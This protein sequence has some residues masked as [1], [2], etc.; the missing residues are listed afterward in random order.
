MHGSKEASCPYSPTPDTFSGP[1]ALTTSFSDN[2]PPCMFTHDH[3]YHPPDC[4]YQHATQLKPS[5]LQTTD[6]TVADTPINPLASA[7][8]KHFIASLGLPMK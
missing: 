7:K 8:G 6:N 2:H 4:T 5:G 3:Q 1:Q